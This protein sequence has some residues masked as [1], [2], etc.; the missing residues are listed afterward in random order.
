MRLFQI[1]TILFFWQSLLWADIPKSFEHRIYEENGANHTLNITQLLTYGEVEFED[2]NTE[3]YLDLFDS[4]NFDASIEFRKVFKNNYQ[5]GIGITYTYDGQ[6]KKR[7]QEIQ[8]LPSLFIE[9]NGLKSVNLIGAKTFVNDKYIQTIKLEV[10]GG[11]KGKENKAY[12][13]GIDAYFSYHFLYDTGYLS[14]YL[15]IYN[16]A[17]FPKKMK[18]LDGE[19]EEQ[20]AYS[21]VFVRLGGLYQ[22]EK[23]YA[24]G[25]LGFGLMTDYEIESPSYHRVADKGFR[26]YWKLG[27]GYQFS[28]AWTLQAQY[29]RSSQVFN[30][31]N[32]DPKFTDVD[33]EIETDEYK[34]ELIWA[35]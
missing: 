18:R 27:S 34:L 11:P 10:I 9:P 28:K 21:E 35:F 13:G 7:Y 19:V 24:L 20:R 4:R 23:F 33:Y 6:L 14:P 22:R 32:H 15:E 30:S 17:S 2:V 31:K 5:F 3:E 8:G 25:S 29:I 16:L 1:V 12:Y 26:T